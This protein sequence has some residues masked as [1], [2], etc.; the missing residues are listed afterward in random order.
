MRQVQTYLEA[1]SLGS[2]GCTV[3]QAH[4]Q[5]VVFDRRTEMNYLVAMFQDPG[6][7]GIGTATWRI[8][9]LRHCA[10]NLRFP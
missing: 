8:S 4:C 5:N 1:P 9:K 3:L 7:G 6:K 10:Q 2:R